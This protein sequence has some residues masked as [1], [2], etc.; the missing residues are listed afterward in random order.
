VSDVATAIHD[1]T[2][3]L[4]LSAETSAGKHPIEAVKVMAR[5]ACET[6]LSLHGKGFPDAWVSDERTT[7]DIIADA[8]YHCARWAGVKAL[9][10]ATS[11]GASARLLSRYRPPVPIYA[12]CSSESVA[13]Q[14]SV[15]Y[16]VTAM[17]LPSMT[18]TDQMLHEMERLLLEAGCVNPRENVVFVAGQPVGLRGSTNMLTLHRLS[19]VRP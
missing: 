5:I 8:A 18:S 16:G 10:V 6:E 13:R 7:P 12:F 19:G 3:A 2:S 14:L 15:A 4:M 1:G 9:A 17:L 11:S